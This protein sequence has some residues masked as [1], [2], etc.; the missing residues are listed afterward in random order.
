MPEVL[1]KLMNKILRFITL[2]MTKAT[3]VTPNV[4]H[5]A[6]VRMSHQDLLRLAPDM[7]TS[8]RHL[9]FGNYREIVTPEAATDSAASHDTS[10]AFPVCIRTC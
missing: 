1:K 10:P 2:F 4:F 9:I 3:R 7:V 8:A 6:D 5:V